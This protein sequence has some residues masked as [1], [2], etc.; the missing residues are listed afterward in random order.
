[1]LKKYLLKLLDLAF[2]QSSKV[3]NLEARSPAELYD[4]VSKPRT[5]HDDL[6]ISALFDYQNEL[7]RTMIWQLKYRGSDKIAKLFAQCLYEELVSELAEFCTLMNI[8]KPL[9]IPVPLSKKRRLERGFN[10]SELVLDALQKIDTSRIF[11]ISYTLLEKHIH[12][13]QQTAAQSREERLKNL[14]N[15]FRVRSPNLIHN[16]TIILLDDV[17]TTGSSMKEARAALLEAGARDVWCVAV[18]H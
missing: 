10:Q 3:T 11:E 14:K 1:M 15:C 6:A 16:R 5:I 4:A 7:M 9:L 12:T 8:R 17:I 13:I 2:P 18:A